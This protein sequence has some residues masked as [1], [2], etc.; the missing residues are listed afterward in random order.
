MLFINI[1]SLWKIHGQSL[2]LRLYLSEKE[3][4]SALLLRSNKNVGTSEVQNLDKHV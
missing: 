3:R 2:Y 4:K 1:L